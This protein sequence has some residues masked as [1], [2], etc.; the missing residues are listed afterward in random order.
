L[1]LD[2]KWFTKPTDDGPADWDRALVL[3]FRS[4]AEALDFSAE[5]TQKLNEITLKHYGT[6]EARTKHD[7]GQ[8]D[9]RDVVS[10]HLVR[11]LTVNPIK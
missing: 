8:R 1:I 2:Y 6:A 9:L 10:S 4:Y 11:E 7:D 5:R 3:V